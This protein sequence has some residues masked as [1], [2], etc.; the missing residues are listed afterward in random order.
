MKNYDILSHFL[1][2]RL[3][4]IKTFNKKFDKMK[5]KQ[6][7]QD[8]GHKNLDILITYFDHNKQRYFRKNQTLWKNGIEKVKIKII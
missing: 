1:Y 5:K 8:Q 7:W 4:Y 2:L 6:Y 3:K